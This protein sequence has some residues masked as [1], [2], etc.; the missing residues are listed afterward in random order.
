VMT[1]KE[2]L[3][4]LMRVLSACDAESKSL[5]DHLMLLSLAWIERAQRLRVNAL[6]F[7]DGFPEEQTLQLEKLEK[8]AALVRAD[9]PDLELERLHLA[10]D[11][12]AVLRYL[13][14]F[15]KPSENDDAP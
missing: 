4:A 5:D 14:N 15:Q 8:M 7:P 11:V 2:T 6:I 12:E 1:D 9:V 13:N 3:D 10:G